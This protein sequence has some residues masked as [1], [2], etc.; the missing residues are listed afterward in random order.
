MDDIFKKSA[1]PEAKGKPDSAA[2]LVGLYLP[3]SVEKVKTHIQMNPET[4][5]ALWSYSE[6][7]RSRA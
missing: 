5:E 2:E 7:D 4:G 1:H 6:P 3:N